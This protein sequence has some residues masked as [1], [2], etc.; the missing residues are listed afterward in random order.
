MAEYSIRCINFDDEKHPEE[1]DLNYQYDINGYGI[2]F[3]ESGNIEYHDK[4]STVVIPR[5]IFE[6]MMEDY[7]KFKYEKFKKENK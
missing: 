5:V 6:R 7:E 2:V 4:Q 1:Y 3:T